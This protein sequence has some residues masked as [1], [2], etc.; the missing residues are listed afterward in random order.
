MV[1]TIRDEIDTILL[2]LDADKLLNITKTLEINVREDLKTKRNLLRLIQKHVDAIE[3]EQH[4][5]AIRD[6]FKTEIGEDIVTDKK[7]SEDDQ[8]KSDV[9]QLEDDQKKSDD[10]KSVVNDNT[11]SGKSFLNLLGATGIDDERSAFHKDF[12]IRGFIGDMGQKDK[13][14]Y[15]SLLKQIE[16]GQSKGYSDKE[17]VNAV[18]RAITPGLYLRNVLETTDNL[19]LPR[20]MKFLQSH[21]VERNTTDLCQH[22][23]SITQGSQETAVQ[24]V[25]RAM[26]LRQKLIVSSKSPAAEIKYDQNLVQRLFL[27]SL[28][29]GISSETIVAE[30]KPLLRNPSVSDEDLIFAVGQASSSDRQRS[31]K[32]NKSKPRV[33]ALET[34]YVEN[35]LLPNKQDSHKHDKSSELV[36]ILKNLQNELSS[37]RIEVNTL[38]EDKKEKTG[39]E[40]IPENKYLC[41]RCKENNED[42]CHHCFKC[43]GEGHVAR[44]CP[45]NRGNGGGLRN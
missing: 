3:E 19:T 2:K 30:M 39:E 25:Y 23:S 26:S 20:L 17:I 34:E 45:S 24:F 35:E 44:K 13:L 9:I 29:T 18:L 38:K 22:L 15:I 41:K 5:K 31:V 42:V 12:K 33:H 1:D 36:D 4:L 8:K 27:K 10:T 14:S 16:E 43:Y 40:S 21:F 32:L 28:E 11:L 6:D 7:K 37:L